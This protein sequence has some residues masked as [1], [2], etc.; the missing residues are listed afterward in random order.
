M[1]IYHV[2]GDFA[3][4]KRR[5]RGIRWE[6]NFRMILPGNVE[7]CSLV[8]ESVSAHMGAHAI[9]A[10]VPMATRARLYGFQE[11]TGGAIGH[12]S[13]FASTC[14]FRNTRIAC[15]NWRGTA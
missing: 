13:S 15:S 1:P 3:G 14:H 6:R 2:H 8:D 10:D 12:R 7:G 11:D 5:S 4:R 9:A